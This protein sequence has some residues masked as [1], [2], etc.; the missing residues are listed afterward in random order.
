MTES[1]K[2]NEFLRLIMANQRPI[3]AFILS[4]LPNRDDAEDIFQETVLVMWSKFD[5]FERGTSFA[6]WGTTVAR[7]K[8]L[9]AHRR[10]VRHNFRLSQAAIQSVQNHSDNFVQHIER[11]MKALRK[12]VRK[13]N[14]RD[15]ELIQM[16]YE[17]ELSIKTIAERLN[18]SVQSIYKRMARINDS[19]IRCIRRTLSTEELA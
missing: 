5:S 8:I 15:Y 6:A 2:I 18:R 12:C 13:L 10:N 1:S 19:L 4:M 17:H 16:R 14:N 3:Y 7:Y 9:Q 11:R